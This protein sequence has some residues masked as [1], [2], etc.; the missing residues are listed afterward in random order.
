MMQEGDAEAISLLRDGVEGG[1]IR[2]LER[3]H[4]PSARSDRAPPHPGRSALLRDVPG[5]PPRSSRGYPATVCF[6]SGRPF[7]RSADHRRTPRK[8][9]AASETPSPTLAWASSLPVTHSDDRQADDP[10][11]HRTV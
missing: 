11:A 3:R 4:A 8:A 5:P 9:F 6:A 2:G 10:L 1:D 7:H